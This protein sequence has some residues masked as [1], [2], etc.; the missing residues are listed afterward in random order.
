MAAGWHPPERAITQSYGFC[1]T[2]DGFIVLVE[3]HGGFLNLPGGQL[4]PAETA[5]DALSREIAEEACAKL[6]ACRYLAGQHVWD[7]QTADGPTS[8][9]QTRWW[10]RVELEPWN[11]RYEI[12]ARHLVRPS[13]AVRMLSWRRKEIAGRILELAL[14]AERAYGASVS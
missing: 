2:P 11:P 7:P 1:F 12:V 6:I 13:D 8:H 3:E 14:A 4:E 9:Y 5:R 10:A